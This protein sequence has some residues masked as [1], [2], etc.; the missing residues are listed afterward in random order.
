M[1]G[2][3]ARLDLFFINNPDYEIYGILDEWSINKVENQ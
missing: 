1:W 2:N 3:L